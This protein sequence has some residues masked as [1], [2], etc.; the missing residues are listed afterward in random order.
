MVQIGALCL[1]FAPLIVAASSKTQTSH[2]APAAYEIV[3]TAAV[4][5]LPLPLHTFF[6]IH[7]DTLRR[8][9]ASFGKPASGTG[10][11]SEN[12]GDHYILLDVTAAHNDRNARRVAARHFPHDRT[13]A[14][15]LF[16]KHGVPDG[17]TLPW[18]IADRHAALAGA[19]RSGDSD[20][21]IR[22]AAI[23]LHFAV[24]ASLPFNTT[25]D[26]AGT[27]V[28]QLYQSQETLAEETKRNGKARFRC[29]VQL[30]DHLQDRLAYEVRVWPGRLQPLGDPVEAVFTALL[31]AHA[32]VDELCRMDRSV[33]R[34]LGI[35][36]AQMSTV[37]LEAYYARLGQ[38]AAPVLESRLESGALLA[39]RLIAAAWNEAGNP[40]MPGSAHQP[41]AASLP[42]TGESPPPLAGSQHSTVFHRK[43]CHHLRRIKPQNLVSFGSVQEAKADGRT[44]CQACKPGAEPNPP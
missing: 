16:D 32:V 19:F 34:E 28:T 36:D 43:G 42:R 22:E 41:I 15:K 2:A 13:A 17:G 18:V 24:D 20:L 23:L 30:V 12:V 26:C 14:A 27:A 25:T 35:Q 40:A 37:A 38:R 7:V 3:A 39:A 11:F 5:V 10:M 21:I 44:P 4:E 6:R 1:A 9:S 33:M 31:E 29:Q 8:G